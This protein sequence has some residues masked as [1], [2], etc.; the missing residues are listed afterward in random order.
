MIT[1]YKCVFPV[2]MYHFRGKWNTI[3][4]K[5]KWVHYSFNHSLITNLNFLLDFASLVYKKNLNIKKCEIMEYRQKQTL[6]KHYGAHCMFYQD[7]DSL[8][9]KSY[10][11]ACLK[12]K[13]YP[14]I[15]QK[16]FAYSTS[17]QF[18]LE[19]EV[20]LLVCFTLCEHGRS[21]TAEHVLII[22]D[23]HHSGPGWLQVLYIWGRNIW[24]SLCMSVGWNIFLGQNTCHEKTQ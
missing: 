5:K 6:P 19:N 3:T 21:A 4:L 14:F 22:P 18:I 7:G 2:F 13:S 15:Q 1:E 11:K 24:G 20:R 12:K 16:S 17:V 8:Q 10:L 9:K 23:G